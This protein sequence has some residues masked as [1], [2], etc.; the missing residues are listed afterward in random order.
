M[1]WRKVL[2]FSQDSMQDTAHIS[3][4]FPLLL[5]FFLQWPSDHLAATRLLMDIFTAINWI[6]DKLKKK[7][8]TV[9]PTCLDPP[10]ALKERRAAQE[11][12]H[13]HGKVMS[14]LLGSQV[15]TSSSATEADVRGPFVAS[16]Q[17]RMSRRANYTQFLRLAGLGPR[18]M[19]L[20]W[21]WAVA[22]VTACSL[23]A[24][25]LTCSILMAMSKMRGFCGHSEC[26]SC[27]AC[28][29]GSAPCEHQWD[30]FPL[31]VIATLSFL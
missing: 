24:S 2:F 6:T 7:S 13:Y 3:C 29:P 11:I 8:S 5:L 27:A 22:H 10:P 16:L 25:A 19:L 21:Q 17:V 4:F 31:L 12:S 26:L 23:L 1:R 20:S 18:A 28:A 30:H 9:K 14:Y 15:R